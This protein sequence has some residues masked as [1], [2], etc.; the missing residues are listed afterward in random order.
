VLPA[1][2]RF[3]HPLDDDP[4]ITS[5]PSGCA[6][7]AA[8]TRA[9]ADAAAFKALGLGKDSRVLLINSEGDLGEPLT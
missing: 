3:A 2:R 1:R 9:C 4:A 5:G 6:G 8:L 7:L